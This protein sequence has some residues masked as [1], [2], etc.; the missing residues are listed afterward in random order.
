MARVL[1]LLALFSAAVLADPVP[2]CAFGTLQDYINS[3]SAGCF[4]GATQFFDFVELDIPNGAIQIDPATV[5]VTPINV[6]ARPQLDFTV[7]A[8]AAA[9]KFFDLRFGYTATGSFI[10]GLGLSMTGPLVTG[11]GAVTVLED[12]CLG[13]AFSFD[14][15]SSSTASLAVF[16]TDFDQQL[17]DALG[18]SAVSTLGVIKD[19][20][21]DGGVSGTAALQS[22]TNQLTIVPE[23]GTA[24]MVGTVLLGVA[25]LRRRFHC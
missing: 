11:D 8:N 7:N 23:P 15:C 14:L 22:A 24:V 10:G 6:Q 12:A 1:F 21:V 19:I 18:F 17:S 9:G 4:I 3:G 20:G 2:Q 16:A 25:I 5:L 13:D